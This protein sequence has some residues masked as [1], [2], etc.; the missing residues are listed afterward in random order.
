MA[1]V[2]AVTPTQLFDPVDVDRQL[3][4]GKVLPPAF[5]TDASIRRL[6][7]SLI[8]RHAWQM[9]CAELDV[10]EPGQYVTT[11]IASVP[12]VVVRDKDRVLHAF[13]NI[14]THRA[15]PI[16]DEA[17]GTCHHMRCGYHGWAFA[18]DGRL[19][20]VPKFAEGNLPPLET[21]GLRPLPIGTFAGIVF[22]A[23]EPQ[24]TLGEQVGELAQLMTEAGYDFPFSNP[25]S[26]LEPIAEHTGDYSVDANWKVVAEN[27]AECYHCGPTHP[28]TFAAALE[29]GKPDWAL[30][31][32]GKFG[33][34][35]GLPLR[36]SMKPKFEPR[37]A[38]YAG[39]PYG[40]AQFFVW[41]NA[42]ILT[43]AIGDHL[44]RLD[45]TGPRSTRLAYWGYKRPGLPEDEVDALYKLLMYDGGAEDKVIMEG[46]QRGLESG[47]YEAGPTMAGPEAVV[48][49]FQRQ[50]WEAL[51]PGLR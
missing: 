30:T 11:E 7:E 46:V 8:F 39:S 15:N 25:Q 41:P 20:A 5:Y 6:E 50:V 12:V 32:D 19:T 36:K 51:A 10:R 9:V 2:D 40:F 16:M 17:A 23:L 21:L 1:T 43:G 34:A 31:Q 44:M 49:A 13:V 29:V 48:S 22:V 35:A 42:L 45:P 28:G 4:A 47:F 3:E 33:L 26:G 27:F 38:E 24:E 37:T 18:L 14:C